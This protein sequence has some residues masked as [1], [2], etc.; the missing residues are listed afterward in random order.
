[1]CAALACHFA[2]SAAMLAVSSAHRMEVVSTYFALLAA[3]AGFAGWRTVRLGY[4]TWAG[5]FAGAA[6]IGGMFVL[7]FAVNAG[8]T[9]S[10]SH[11]PG[12]VPLG[13]AA[14]GLLVLTIIAMSMGLL[15]GLL[16][17]RGRH[18]SAT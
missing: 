16:A 5:A 12:G 6:A 1:M 4:A 8:I 11:G 7:F 13:R 2:F 10:L 14:L 9:G 17:K 15:G 3:V 18:A